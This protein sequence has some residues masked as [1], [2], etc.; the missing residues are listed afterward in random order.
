[1]KQVWRRQIAKGFFKIFLL[2]LCQ[3]L[4]GTLN[5]EDECEL[6]F[7]KNTALDDYVLNPMF[8]QDY[9]LRH[10]PYRSKFLTDEEEQELVELYQ[11]TKN[12][13]KKQEIVNKILSNYIRL[14]I[15]FARKISNS[16]GRADLFE[17]L[18]QDANWFIMKRLEKHDPRR[19]SLLPFITAFVPKFMSSKISVYMSPVH[20]DDEGRKE[21]KK[22][23][24][25]MP[26]T[27]EITLNINSETETH[28]NSIEGWTE[29]NKNMKQIEDF[30]LS[31][32]STPRQRYI[33]THRIF[34]FEPEPSYS[35][36]EKFEIHPS[37]VAIGVEEKK[38]IQKISDHLGDG[39]PMEQDQIFIEVSKRIN[40]G[41]LPPLMNS[42]EMDFETKDLV[43]QIKYLIQE[44]NSTPEQRRALKDQQAENLAKE[45]GLDEINKYIL[46]YRLLEEL[47]NRQTLKAIGK[48]FGVSLEAI[49][50]REK[51]ILKKLQE[52]EFRSP[53]LKETIDRIHLS[54]RRKKNKSSCYE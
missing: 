9:L 31:L 13:A 53:E 16:R 20:V 15:K 22:Q 42:S 46:R 12:H 10:L 51:S 41:R 40:E 36:A 30:I 50:F 21:I 39:S 3:P 7:K 45:A 18:V 1:M 43:I 49:L 25:S 26:I 38:L 34:T 28:H 8:S 37:G 23:G 54:V 6:E 14:V 35:I 32:G 11:T 27:V 19:G 24:L 2:F 4:F 52:T 17:D 47:T 33:L 5:T 48:M 44:I 29:A